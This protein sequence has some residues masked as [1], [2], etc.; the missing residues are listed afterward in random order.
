MGNRTVFL[1]V[2]IVVVHVSASN[3]VRRRAEQIARIPAFGGFGG[4]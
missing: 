2:D 4:F 1:P 3:T